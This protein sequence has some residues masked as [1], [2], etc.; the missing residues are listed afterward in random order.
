MARL[1]LR[2]AVLCSLC[3]V[4]HGWAQLVN[5]SEAPPESCPRRDK[6]TCFSVVGG[7]GISAFVLHF[8]NETMEVATTV[9][10]GVARGCANVHS[11]NSAN[12]Q[13]LRGGTWSSAIPVRMR[14]ATALLPMSLLAPPLP[15]PPRPPRSLHGRAHNPIPQRRM[16]MKIPGVGSS[17]IVEAA[18]VLF[19][20]C[21]AM[22]AA[23]RLRR[24]RAAGKVE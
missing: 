3:A 7:D 2:A 9:L 19:A 24:R 14:G 6:C 11:D 20:T 5:A 8:G 18:L 22:C 23:R 21:C 10:N 13:F 17:V 4:V 16:V 15:P 12:M 1:L